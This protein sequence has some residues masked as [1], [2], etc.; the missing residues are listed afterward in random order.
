MKILHISDLHYIK[1]RS[2][3]KI[4]KYKKIIETLK[5]KEI[6]LILFTGDLVDRKKSKLEDG[7]NFL[8]KNIVNPLSS[9]I[10]LCCGN[11]DIDRVKISDMFKGHIN[12]L[13]TEEKISNFIMENKNNDFKNS[14]K[15]IKEYNELMC[16][17]ACISIQK[18][19]E[20]SNHL[21]LFYF[22]LI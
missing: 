12:R 13:D 6:D 18:G 11:H 5:D 22:T 16:H 14:I 21:P 9:K 2:E 15:H 8:M 4:D 20:Y 17:K 1:N 10:Y 19:S 7:Y 3:K